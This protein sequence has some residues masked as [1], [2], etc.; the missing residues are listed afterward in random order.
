[1]FVVQTGV[2]VGLGLA[3]QT[4]AQFGVGGEAAHGVGQ[5]AGIA[6]LDEQAVLA[7][8]DVFALAAVVRGHHGPSLRHVLLWRQG[9]ALPDGRCQHAEVGA[10]H[11]GQDGVAE[12]GQQYLVAE[13]LLG[14][15]LPEV[16]RIVVAAAAHQ[17]QPQPRAVVQHGGGLNECVEPLLGVEPAV[18]HGYDAVAVEPHLA[19]HVNRLQLS[20]HYDAGVHDAQLAAV[21]G[22]LG[23]EK[24]VLRDMRVEH[25]A[26]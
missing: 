16:G 15:E 4:A 24:H 9:A 13:A 1:M 20:G 19:A 23:T 17:H 8:V 3:A 7:V 18:E 14:D 11:V 21:D 2:V 10:S 6:R 26:V 22:G 25:E 12:T 5:L